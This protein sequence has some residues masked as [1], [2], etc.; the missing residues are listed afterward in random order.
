MTEGLLS[1]L[2]SEVKPVNDTRT[3]I[4]Q[5]LRNLG[6]Q[7]EVEQYLKQYASVESTKFAVIKIGGGIVRDHLD[8]LVSS[9]TFLS[10]VGLYP[11]IIHG[12]GEQLSE[13]LRMEGHQPTFVD[14]LRVTDAETLR[15]ARKVFT[16][17][18]HQICDALEAQGTRARPIPTGVFEAVKS[19]FDRLGYVGE[20]TDVDLE[21]IRSAIQ[22]G[23]IPVLSSLAETRDG[24]LLNI[25]A[26][27]ATR[28]LATKIEPYKIIFLT[29]TA[30]LLDAEGHIIS[31]INLAEDYDTLMEA[32]WVSG[33][34]RLKIQEV[35]ALV[36]AL[37]LQ[38]SVAIT[39]P[40]ELP[41]ELFTH[42]GSG[43][44]IR[45]G[46]RVL[47]FE[48]GLEGVDLGRLQNLLES[49][50][51]RALV[52]DYFEKKA[53][54]KIYVTESYRATAILTEEGPIPYLDKFAVTSKAQGEGI[55]ASLWERLRK[56][57]P[58][59]FWR[60][61][62]ENHTINPWYFTKSDGSLRDARWIVFWYGLDGFDEIQACIARAFAMPPSLRSHGIAE[63]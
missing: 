35:K 58:K 34:M 12:A 59:L 45:K 21:P 17:T 26:D 30:G 27:T 32:P 53:F 57:N 14:G 15:M 31:A 19:D 48:G 55:A 20:V 40:S 50:F 39:S 4:S 44:L 49:S 43:T 9:L 54:S 33:G 38:S 3:L 29:P 56:D 36:D 23:D 18:N 51:Q 25:N 52:D 46:E 6:T 13:A 7:R 60:S 41:K 2:S 1:S 24:Q 28:H 63:G 10:R 16:R 37:P 61:R 8:D 62:V 5:L 47:L 11:I 42:R 22:A